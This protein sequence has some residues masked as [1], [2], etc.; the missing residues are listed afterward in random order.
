MRKNYL[1]KAMPFVVALTILAVPIQ[2]AQLIT[3][4]G[5]EPGLAGWTVADQVGSD[6]AFMLQS[7]TSSPVLGDPVPSPPGP[8]HAAMTD[9]QGPGSHLMYQDFA[10]P[11]AVV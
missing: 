11:G 8:T 6:G 2:A 7:G 4:G 10:V 9:A 1:S 3:N 5:F